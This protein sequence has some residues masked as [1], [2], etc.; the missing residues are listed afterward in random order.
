MFLDVRATCYVKKRW[1]TFDPKCSRARE[2]RRHVVTSSREKLNAGLGNATYRTVDARICS[3][4]QN[5]RVY[6]LQRNENKT[7]KRIENDNGR[8]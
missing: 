3:C 8:A 6:Q 1:T 2:D 4:M 7:E 5:D